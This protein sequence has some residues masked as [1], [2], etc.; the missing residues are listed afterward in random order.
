L[1]INGKTYFTVSGLTFETNLGEEVDT[2]ER[3]RSR[4]KKK[5]QG[6]TVN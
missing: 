1:K 5:K 3:R 2:E 4:R 6:S